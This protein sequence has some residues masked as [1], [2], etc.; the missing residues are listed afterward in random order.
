MDKKIWIIV[1][2]AFLSGFIQY[3]YHKLFLVHSFDYAVFLQTMQNICINGSMFNYVEYVGHGV[4]THFAV[5]FQPILY[6]Y[7]FVY[8]VTKS[9]YVPDFF[10]WLGY[11]LLGVFTYKLYRDHKNILPMLLLWLISPVS[12]SFLYDAHPIVFAMPFG[13]LYMYAA[14]RKD[15]KLMLL[16]A[17]AL[18]T[19]KEDTALFPVAMGVYWI[20]E[21]EWKESLINF[22]VAGVMCITSVA[23]ILHFAGGR[24]VTSDHFGFDPN[25]FILALFVGGIILVLAGAPF[26]Y[27]KKQ[28]RYYIVLTPLLIE[29]LTFKYWFTMQFGRQYY[30]FAIVGLIW[31]LSKVHFDKRKYLAALVIISV[32]LSPVFDGIALIDGDNYN[33]HG[34]FLNYH[35]NPI[36]LVKAYHDNYSEYEYLYTA[37]PSLMSSYKNEGYTVY[38]RR[39]LYEKFYTVMDV[40]FINIF[41]NQSTPTPIVKY[42]SGMYIPTSGSLVESL[43]K[44]VLI[45]YETTFIPK[46]PCSTY[47]VLPHH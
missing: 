3:M 35:A 23:V 29:P 46:I 18:F 13:L 43:G 10:D 15:R 37:V 5:H 16:S 45:V 6:F 11:V 27:N 12:Y 22:L 40:N 30:S 7:A 2:G 17:L 20:I 44:C 26:L 31:V 41:Y 19:I 33:I 32:V 8:Y 4:T 28:L 1:T 47:T 9:V 25:A 39:G 14:E 21:R 38:L 34:V 24:F 36:M 42:W